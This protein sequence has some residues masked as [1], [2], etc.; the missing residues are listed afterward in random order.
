MLSS[1]LLK[2]ILITQKGEYLHEFFARCQEILEPFV[3]IVCSAP[4]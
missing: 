2:K 1:A 3:V 4:T